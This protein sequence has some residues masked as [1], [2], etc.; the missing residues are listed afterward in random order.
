[1]RQLYDSFIAKF[2]G[3]A[4]FDI[5]YAMLDNFTIQ[6]VILEDAPGRNCS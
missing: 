4:D 2:D 5:I 6:T 3:R 1:M